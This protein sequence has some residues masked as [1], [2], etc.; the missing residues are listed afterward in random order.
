[1]R[2]IDY[3]KEKPKPWILSAAIAGPALI[4]FAL[5]P[6]LFL[7]TPELPPNLANKD[8]AIL[9]DLDNQALYAYENG[10]LVHRFLAISG[11]L[12]HETPPG[13]YKVR[14]KKESHHSRE[15]DAP[16]PYTMFIIEERG[17]AIHAGLAIGAKWRAKKLA[18]P[19][20]KTVGSHGCVGLEL[21]DAKTLF[22][23]A[24]MFTPV[25]VRSDLSE[26]LASN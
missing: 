5:L 12:D 20:T 13:S 17:I 3:I 25:V 6:T 26:S 23:W 21:W 9:I 2:L 4:A 7:P 15:F 18:P 1:M 10:K 24:P 8:K 16:M 19:L 11:A 14:T 22:E